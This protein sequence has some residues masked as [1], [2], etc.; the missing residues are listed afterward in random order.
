M[1]FS[2]L[3]AAIACAAIALAVPAFAQAQIAQPAHV[4]EK[5]DLEA[6]L[7][8]MMPYAL[9]NGDI[10]GMVIAVVKDGHVVLQKGYGY[11]DVARKTPMDPVRTMVRA[12]STS[13]LFTWTAVMQLVEQ[14]KLD[15]DRDV[16]AY[17]DFTIPHHGGKAV[18]LRDLMNHRAGF[19]EGLKD[20]LA[21]DP[22]GLQ[23]TEQY[24]KAHPR[25]FLFT[26]GTVPAYSNYGA[27]LAGYIVERVSGEPFE[28]YVERHIL[29]P[30]GMN[31]TSFYQPLQARFRADVSQGYV[32]AS[33]APQAYEL[34]VTR[35]AGSGTTTAADM[36]NF[37]IA[38]LQS[39]R[40]GN[41][42]I[43]SAQTEALMQN[44]SEKALPGFSTM[45][46]G[47][48]HDVHNGT[49]V[50]G[51][52]GDT[53]VFH[54]E[55]DLLPQK[56]VGIY[57][58]FNSRGKQDAVYGLRQML[59][60]N[61]MDRY[62]PAA[63]SS[64]SVPTMTAAAQDAQAIA[65]SYESS[66]RVEHGFLSLFY[67]LQ[68][69]TI[70]A[71]ADGTIAGPGAPGVDGTTTF[72]EIGP[73]LWREVGGTRQLALTEV[74]GV[75]TVV[76][77]ADPISVLQAVPALRSSSLNLT[78]LLGS[79]AVLLWSLVLWPLS[80]LLRRA[81][82]SAIGIS[83][84]LRRVRWFVLGAIVADVVYLFAWAMLL[85]PVLGSQLQAYSTKIDGIVR[86][87]QIA[88]VLPLAA[89]AVGV[90]AV[91]QTFKLQAPWLSRAWTIAQAAALLGIVWIA[92]MGN[93]L[94]F[95][96]NY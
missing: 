63:A 48:F 30:L 56:G 87:L 80:P 26:P 20:I 49:V 78:I 41:A 95:N 53:V 61:F 92:A 72:R 37:M 76:D 27:S 7:D 82:G 70:G 2:R 88:G 4:L 81:D 68:H 9:K 62:F 67:L 60:D 39:G 71:N 73:Q 52:G 83:P 75:K 34:V 55:L 58:T 25:P 77:S 12:G 13:K 66:R 16:N 51:H 23:S 93:L 57:Y 17:I 86:T 35:P 3:K 84:A 5:S 28:A 36:A 96:L 90:W 47:F 31:R 44:P 19:E 21:T 24:L 45:A 54:T 79:V 8:G 22:N 18:T 85:Q 33:G 42:Q 32:T 74:N 14:H 43:L 59:F 46:H 15:L 6:W 1:H 10:A 94:G 65:G 89:V 91:W 69:T 50:I 64:D 29:L 11:S 40:L 38:H